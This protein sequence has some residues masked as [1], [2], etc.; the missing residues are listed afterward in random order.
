[1]FLARVGASFRRTLGAVMP[2]TIQFESVPDGLFQS[3]A[4]QGFVFSTVVTQQNG[5]PDAFWNRA[6]LTDLGTGGY[7]IN[8]YSSDT[9]VVKSAT[10]AAFGATS[11]ALN[12]FA[13]LG[14]NG[15]TPITGTSQVE[16][17]FT[18]VKAD[19]TLVSDYF[20]TDNIDGFQTVTLNAGFASGLV[21]INWFTNLGTGWGA[22]DNLV[23]QLNTAPV[24]SPFAGSILAGQTFT[25]HLVATDAENQPL[26]YQA[27]GALPAGVVLDADGTF[28]VQPLSG[29]ADLTTARTVSFQY[30]AFDGSDYSA[31]KSVSVTLNP[32]G[33]GPDIV[34]GNHPQ[35]LVGTA[36]GEKIWGGNSG[37]TLSGLG[38]ADTLDGANGADSLSGGDGKD[39]L[40]G[41]NG[42]DWLD[43]GSGDDLLDGGNSPDTLAGGAGN[44][45]I[46][47]GNS[48][49]Y[50]IF[51]ANFGRDVITDFDAK[52]EVIQISPAMFGSFTDLMAHAQQVG[53][54][55]VITADANNTLTLL[56][57]KLSS[58]G[59]DDFIF[60]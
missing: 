4:E 36:R 47:G 25:G 51:G 29:D 60:S 58:L 45:T 35:V 13:F 24:A 52:N 55:V 16:F 18:G 56:N 7:L 42:S 59:M 46:T 10:G 37:D 57:V 53:T 43:G 28:Y 33:V 32:V 15:T 8:Q 17:Y 50:F 40:I 30:R 1:M 19:G 6:N 5:F 38:G 11:I 49:D 22:F 26:S 14:F 9:V 44:D 2:I 41:G 3:Y 23:L 20:K 54:S 21:E 39:K 12:G 31:A 34:G 27:V 48:P